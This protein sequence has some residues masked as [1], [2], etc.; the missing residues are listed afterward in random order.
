MLSI[1]SSITAQWIIRLHE[2]QVYQRSPGRVDLK[3]FVEKDG[4][5]TAAINKGFSLACGDIVCWLNTD[6]WFHEGAL[7]ACFGILLE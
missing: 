6:E 7:Q 4:G 5:Q 1:L 3:V 2:L